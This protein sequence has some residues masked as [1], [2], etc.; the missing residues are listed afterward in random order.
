[1]RS[2]KEGAVSYHVIWDGHESFVLK[3]NKMNMPEQT[4]KLEGDRFALNSCI[5]MI[6]NVPE[7]GIVTVATDSFTSIINDKTNVP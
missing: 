1:M 7:L 3:C 2:P 4:L 6:M 5:T